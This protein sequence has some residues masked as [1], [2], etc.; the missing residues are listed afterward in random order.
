MPE[1]ARFT[2]LLIVRE[3]LLNIFSSLLIGNASGNELF[4]FTVG[5]MD[6]IYLVRLLF[7]H[8]LFYNGIGKHAVFGQVSHSDGLRMRRQAFIVN[9][10]LVNSFLLFWSKVREL[11]SWAK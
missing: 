9:D 3:S 11:D 5:N 4:D 7:L 1:S 8:N 10:L 6:L 2:M